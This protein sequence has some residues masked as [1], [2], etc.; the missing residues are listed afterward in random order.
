[1]KNMLKT[2]LGRFRLIAL[3]E[4]L[5]CFLL[6]FVAMPL[7]YGLDLPMATRIVGT[8]HGAL[9]VVYGFSLISVWITQ[10]WSIGKAALALLASIPPLGAFAFEHWVLR[11]E[12]PRE[13]EESR[14]GTPAS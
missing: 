8:I 14:R 9:F 6:F 10:R 7:K 13:E 12:T 3:I 1:M 11:H 4:G 5:S 2:T